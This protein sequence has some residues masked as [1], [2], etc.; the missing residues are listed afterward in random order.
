M[1]R[2]V[3][4]PK[5]ITLN[6]FCGKNK[7]WVLKEHVNYPGDMEQEGSGEYFYQCSCG[8]IIEERLVKVLTI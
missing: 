2:Y 4:I 8:T 1:K 7:D 3:D 5:E 6:C